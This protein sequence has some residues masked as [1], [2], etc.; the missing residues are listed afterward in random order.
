[1]ESFWTGEALKYLYLLLDPSPNPKFP[2]D[3]W[4]FNTEAHPLPVQVCLCR[5][6]P[7]SYLTI[8][9]G[10]EN[11]PESAFQGA[12]PRWGSKLPQILR[13]AKLAELAVIAEVCQLLS[14]LG[15]SASDLK[16]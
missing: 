1:M 14:K 7:N 12:S 3:Q 9:S 8:L 13:G 4:V 16:L 15:A 6:H 10:Y 11:A 2:L 5:S